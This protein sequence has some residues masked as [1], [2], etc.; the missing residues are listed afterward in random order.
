MTCYET[1]IQELQAELLLAVQQKSHLSERS[2]SSNDSGNT[3]A[4]TLSFEVQHAGSE[5]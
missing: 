4:A 2:N 3:C 1:R 5:V